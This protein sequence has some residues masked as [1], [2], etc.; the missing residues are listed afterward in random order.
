VR[1]ANHLFVDWLQRRSEDVH[2][3][4]VVARDGLRKFV[5]SGLVTRLVHNRGLHIRQRSNETKL[6]HRWRQRAL[7]P[8]HTS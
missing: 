6:S 5:T 3:D 2:Y 7:L 1:S 8:F 4:F